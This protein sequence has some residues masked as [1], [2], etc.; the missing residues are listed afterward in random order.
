[1][2]FLLRPFVFK[3][4]F[5]QLI[6]IKQNYFN[7][8]PQ[9]VEFSPT[10]R[11]IYTEVAAILYNTAGGWG[12][13]KPCRKVDLK[14]CGHFSTDLSETRRFLVSLKVSKAGFEYL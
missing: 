12:G 4:L 14:L 9:S 1:M 3:A 5:D 2:S 13:L 7:C 6:V 8:P 11:W 10:W